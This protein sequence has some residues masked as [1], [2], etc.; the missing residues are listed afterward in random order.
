MPIGEDVLKHLHKNI[1]LIWR[2]W[3]TSRLGICSK[4]R[5][6]IIEIE[7]F[8]TRSQSIYSRIQNYSTGS[9][10]NKPYHIYHGNKDLHCQY[11]GWIWPFR[12]NVLG[13]PSQ[14]GRS[15]DNRISVVNTPS[16]CI[17]PALATSMQ[18]QNTNIS[19]Y[20]DNNNLYQRLI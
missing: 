3:I 18:S 17:L 2:T 11:R 10:S 12:K 6:G 8:T 15:V 13:K 14:S 4:Q 19:T 7:S 9:G 5:K 1:L 16:E 20:M